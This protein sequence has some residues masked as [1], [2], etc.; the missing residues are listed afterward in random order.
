[1]ENKAVQSARPE[2]YNSSWIKLQDLSNMYETKQAE[3]CTT[4]IEELQLPYIPVDDGLNAL[5]EIFRITCEYSYGK[6]KK[7]IYQWWTHFAYFMHKLLIH[8]KSDDPVGS[9]M[10]LTCV[11][12]QFHSSN[13]ILRKLAGTSASALTADNLKKVFKLTPSTGKE[14]SIMT[15]YHAEETGKTWA[16]KLKSMP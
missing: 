11:I 16:D 14:A 12:P 4:T 15:A 5:L 6:P 1:M 3:N 9:A 2:Y 13:D 10:T 7:Y 8:G